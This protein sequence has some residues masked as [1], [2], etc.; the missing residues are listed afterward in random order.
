MRCIPACGAARK[1]LPAWRIEGA[2]RPSTS[3]LRRLAMKQI[4]PIVLALIPLAAVV[5]ACV[6][7]P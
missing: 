7:C 1:P 6:T 5:G 3:S 4:F 2:D